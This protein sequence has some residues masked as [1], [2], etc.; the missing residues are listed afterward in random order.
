M[1]ISPDASQQIIETLPRLTEETEWIVL[2][3]IPVFTNKITVSHKF[4]WEGEKESQF[5]NQSGPEVQ[6]K[7]TFP[8]S[9]M[10]GMPGY[11]GGN[12]VTADCTPKYLLVD[13]SRKKTA[14][15]TGLNGQT[16][17][18]VMVSVKPGEAHT[19]RWP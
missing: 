10:R 12:A 15:E 8:V 11:C 6:W 14:T 17:V 18:Y 16:R 3:N 2:K 13:G 7:A 9:N 1:G 19:V 4:S 5:V